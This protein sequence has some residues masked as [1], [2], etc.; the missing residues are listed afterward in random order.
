MIIDEIDALGARRGGD[1]GSVGGSQVARRALSALLNE[2][3]GLGGRAGV[4]LLACTSQP[5][6]IDAA[7]LRPGRL[8]ELL[9]VPPPTL[10]DR[11]EILKVCLPGH[12]CMFRG[13]RPSPARSIMRLY[14]VV[15]HSYRQA[16]ARGRCTVHVSV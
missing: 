3:D 12:S 6:A 15:S 4:V 9:L 16:R 5:E 1:D 11:R 8:D 14:Q 2:L 7:L 13:G 10:E